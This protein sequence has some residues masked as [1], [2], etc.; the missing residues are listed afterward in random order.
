MDLT[1]EKNVVELM[2]SSRN[3]TE[4]NANCDLV[5]AA[6]GGYP[7]FWYFAIILNGVLSQSRSNW[8]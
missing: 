6:N 3:E 7:G 4:W 1:V 8:K 2:A 5:K